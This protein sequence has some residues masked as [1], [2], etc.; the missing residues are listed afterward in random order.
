MDVFVSWS[1]GKDCSLAYHQAIRSGLNVRYLASMITESIERLWVHRL[2]P[3]V[4]SLQAQAM[5]I[6]LVLEWATADTYV[7]KYRQMLQGF[8]AEGITGGVFGD[9]SIGNSL[10]DRHRQW[11]DSVCLPEGITPHR[12]LWDQGR[13]EIITDI[14]EQGFEAIIIVADDKLGK[15]FLGRKL[16]RDLLRELKQRH[17]QSPTGEVG[18]YHTFVVDGPLFKKRLE[19]IATNVVHH[20]PAAPHTFAPTKGPF[21]FLDILKCGLRPKASER[22]LMPQRIL[23]V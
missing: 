14:I 12:P 16:D 22:S 21:W 11:V 20:R 15:D 8:R 4:L 17:E 7:D 5:G 1:G 13:E 9:V 18:Y 10:A 3:E 23:S 6:P 2:T 19:I